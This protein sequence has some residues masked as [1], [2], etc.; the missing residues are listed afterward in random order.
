M[1][2]TAQ[3]RTQALERHLRR[4][5]RQIER[6]EARRERVARFRPLIFFLGLALTYWTGWTSLIFAALIMLVESIHYNRIGRRIRRHRLWHSIK[7][8][9]LAR[10]TLDWQHIPEPPP[11]AY[12]EQHPF[13]VDLDIVGGRSLHRLINRAVSRQGSQRLLDWLLNAAP[14]REQIESRRNMLRE[15]IPLSR[16]RDKLL[17]QCLLVSKEHL[18]GDNLLRWLHIH[19]TE[20][21]SSYMFPAALMLAVVNILLFGAFWLGWLPGWWLIS[22]AAYLVI[23]FVNLPTCQ[24]RFDAVMVLYDELDKFKA[25]LHYLEC[26]PYA[27]HPN[28]RHLCAPFWQETPLPS[29]LM[30]KVTWL[31]A[32]VGLRMNPMAGLLLNL[33]FPWDMTAAWFI[34]RY[35]AE[36]A[37]QFPRWVEAWT[38]LEALVSLADFAYLH[39]DCIFPEILED[40]QTPAFQAVALAHPLIPAER[41]VA[42]DIQLAETGDIVLLTG[43]NMAGKSTFLKTVGVNLCL[44][45]AGSVVNATAMQT[46]LFRVYS[47]IQIHDSIA[48]GFSFFYAEVRRLKQ[49]IDAIHADNALPVCVLIDEIF[50]GTNSR[51]RLIGGRAYIQHLAAQRAIGLIATHDLEL[52]QLAEQIGSLR[53]AHFRDDVTEGT[54]MF[55]YRLRP[56]VCP[57]TNALKIMSMNG[58]PIEHI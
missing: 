58:L 50:K 21:R 3:T 24:E 20:T 15:L 26:Y 13:A 52:A 2:P 11:S 56:G 29:A 37:R 22:A 17:L 25:I 19:P 9:H 5:Q 27:N 34:A 33:A 46:R 35:Q 14:Q 4:I 1:K 54:M 8:A 43:S 57:T 42:N 39:P 30:K 12:D 40:A 55:D 16:F 28:L 47:C 31:T 49:M 32:A 41:C 36:C 18:D 45:Y 23:Y 38:E 51:E 6:F 48:D 10:M 53:N 7:S 44:A